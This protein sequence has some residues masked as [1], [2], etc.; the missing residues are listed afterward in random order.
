[1]RPRGRC[2]HPRRRAHHPRRRV[3]VVSS[4]VEPRHVLRR[5]EFHPHHA[6]ARAP[7]VASQRAPSTLHVRELHVAPIGVAVAL[8]A[9]DIAVA[10]EFSEDVGEAIR[11][12]S[13]HRDPSRRRRRGR[14]R[15]AIGGEVG[16]ISGWLGAFAARASIGPGGSHVAR[17]GVVGGG[18]WAQAGG[19]ITAR[20]GRVGR[21]A[22]AEDPLSPRGG[23]RAG[24][25]A[26]DA[27]AEESARA[28][29]RGEDGSDGAAGEVAGGARARV[30]GR[31]GTAVR[32]G[33]SVRRAGEEKSKGA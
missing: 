16:V 11:R 15:D 8:V 7:S 6:A 32:A 26:V 14:R 9:E 5:R 12:E 1:M 21:H 31:G 10:L 23:V 3:A 33:A 25:A 28:A 19:S 24:G 30:G 29:A 4:V 20:R 2:G 22:T 18:G 17:R 27:S 13:K